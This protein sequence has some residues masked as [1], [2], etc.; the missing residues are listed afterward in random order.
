MMKQKVLLLEPHEGLRENIKE[1]LE[2]E[3]Y[4]VKIL[5]TDAIKG[6]F[7]KTETAAVL[8]ISGLFLSEN[9]RGLVFPTQDIPIIVF[10]ADSDDLSYVPFGRW[11]PLPFQTEKLLDTVRTSFD[12]MLILHNN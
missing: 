12:S 5:N 8:L 1:L 11:M 10:S 6:D 3:G 7:T 4:I 9:N 2:L